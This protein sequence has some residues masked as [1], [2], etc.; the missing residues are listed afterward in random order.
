MQIWIF[1]LLPDSQKIYCWQTI[2]FIL[3]GLIIWLFY[4]YGGKS[5]WHIGPIVLET[6]THPQHPYITRKP[7]HLTRSNILTLC[8][9]S[10]VLHQ[11]NQ[12]V[13]SLYNGLEPDNNLSERFL[14]KLVLNT[15]LVSIYT[16]LKP[17]VIVY[18]KHDFFN[19]KF[20]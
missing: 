15:G 17:Y 19:T 2:H 10:P 1:K 20:V 3:C 12:E 16:L 18:E 7:Q 14:S 4:K 8:R 11:E 6:K 13:F 9:N 5:T